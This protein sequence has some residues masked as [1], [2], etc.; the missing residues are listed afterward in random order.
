M[1]IFAPEV[2]AFFAAN[3]W[4]SARSSIK[5]MH[6]LGIAHWTMVHGFYADSG[7]FILQTPD[8]PSFPVDTRALQYLIKEKYLELPVIKKDAI[9]DRSKADKFAKAVAV[10]QTGWMIAQC[11]GRL[12]ESLH[13]TP[14]ELVTV[15]FTICTVASY[16]F[17][18]EKPLNVEG[19]VNLSITTRMSEILKNAGSTAKEPYVDTPMDFVGGCG[20][21]QGPG[22]WGRRHYLPFFGSLEARPLQRMPDDYTPPPVTIRLASLQWALSVIH[23]AI[24]VAGW[25][26]SF[27]TS[28]EKCLWRSA[29]VALLAV[30]FV[31]GLV[32]VIAVRP[33]FDYRLILLG[34]WEKTTISKSKWRR[35]ALS[36]PATAAA[37][38]YVVARL[39]LL[40]QAAA[41]LRS[42]P[43]SVYKTVGWTD[44]IPHI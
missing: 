28:I 12:F 43:C 39:V 25:N 42:M 20:I 31:F 38:L 32:L 11:V 19:H 4:S 40:V 35:W 6:D 36:I 8:M 15:A 23:C 3:Q 9:L 13:I 30:L 27:P 33:W 18:L 16:L 7:G 24:H 10:I 26:Y 5:A 41:A 37:L 22:T 17:W 21:P 34:I 29:S 2:V 1:T 14:L 44:K